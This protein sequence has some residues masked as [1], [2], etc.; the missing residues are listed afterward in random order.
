M[1]GKRARKRRLQ[2]FI[3]RTTK[4]KM[5][6]LSYIIEEGETEENRKKLMDML[7]ESIHLYHRYDKMK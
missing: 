7:R 1:S 2:K 4:E 6:Q 3:S 5:R